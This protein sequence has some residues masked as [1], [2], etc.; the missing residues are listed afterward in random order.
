VV[1]WLYCNGEVASWTYE[2]LTAREPYNK[3]DKSYHHK[4]DFLDD[5]MPHVG[6]E[7]GI[8]LVSWGTA[9]QEIGALYVHYQKGGE[10]YTKK[11]CDRNTFS[12]A[13]PGHFSVIID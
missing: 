6:D 10:H 1:F 5:K 13:S 9:L 3:S 4:I 7:I 8:D 11:L 2:S 12:G